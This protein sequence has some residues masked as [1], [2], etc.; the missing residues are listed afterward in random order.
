MFEFLHLSS[1]VITKHISWI[2]PKE[3]ENLTQYAKR[4][5]AEIDNDAP[6]CLVGLSFG[7]LIAIEINKIFPAKKVIIISS[8]TSQKEIPSTL[9]IV[10]KF[11]LHKITPTILL[12][13]PN[14][15]TYWFF[16]IKT[17]RDK[18]LLKTYIK[19][20]TIH[21]L[22]W[23]INAILS[24]Q[25]KERPEN[26]FHIQGSSDRIFPINK[27]KAD[28]VIPNAGHFMIHNKSEKLNH[29]ISE[30]INKADI[31]K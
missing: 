6:F 18:N 3:Q 10:Y 13:H 17:S 15:F 20:M 9:N 21:Y 5:A 2:E 11:R 14:T 1:N 23:S 31:N 16:G 12:K 22:K 28:V 26:V 30:Q 19:N 29:I 25:N 27:I 24:W 4:M 8:I 7:G